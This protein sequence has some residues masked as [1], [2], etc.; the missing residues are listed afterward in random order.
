MENIEKG[1][2]DAFTKLIFCLFVKESF[3]IINIIPVKTKKTFL[4]CII[5]FIYIDI[6]SF[7]FRKV[8]TLPDSEVGRALISETPSRFQQPLLGTQ[9]LTGTWSFKSPAFGGFQATTV[10]PADAKAFESALVELVVENLAEPT[11]VRIQIK[12]PVH[13]MRDWLVAD[14]ILRPR[15]KGRQKFILHLKGRP[16]INMPPTEKKKYW[17]MNQ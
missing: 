6:V 3:Q 12:E 16:V 10:P 1:F 17:K 5:I 14:A 15:G 2:V 13:G 4:S 8:E 11:P 9:L 7:S